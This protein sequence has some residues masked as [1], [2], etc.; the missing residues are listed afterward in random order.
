[1]GHDFAKR[2]K[3]GKK[4]A[5]QTL[6]GWVWLATGL[7]SGVFASFLVYL[8]VLTP[9]STPDPQSTSTAETKITERAVSEAKRL[10]STS[11]KPRF[12]FYTM[13]PKAEVTLPDTVAE[14]VSK[15]DPNRV[16]YNYTLQAGS[17]RKMDDADRRRAELS[18][19]GLEPRIQTVRTSSQGTW[20]RVHVG[21]FNN[22]SQLSKAR[23]TLISEGIDTLEVK[24]K[25]G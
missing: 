3:A 17:F 13:L 23:Q 22:R 24:Q 11:S 12:D 4:P 8:V 5:K 16:A 14:T 20:H 15:R 9:A 18:L 25:A 10:A 19:L 7:F 21:P 2:K 1:M 6:P